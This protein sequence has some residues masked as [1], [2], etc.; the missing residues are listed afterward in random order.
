MLGKKALVLPKTAVQCSAV[1]WRGIIAW[2][3]RAH[4]HQPRKL[5]CDFVE[6]VCNLLIKHRRPLLSTLMI[7]RW[8][9]E[10]SGNNTNTTSLLHL[11]ASGAAP[12]MTSPGQSSPRG[13]RRASASRPTDSAAGKKKERKEKRK[14]HDTINGPSLPCPMSIQTA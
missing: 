3:N 14:K 2:H 5:I 7:Q 10:T 9:N 11:N 6:T 12:P 4:P 8:T 1:A 13:F